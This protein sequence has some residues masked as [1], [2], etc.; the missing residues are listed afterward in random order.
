MPLTASS[1]AAAL[2]SAADEADRLAP[3]LNDLDGW[4]G[5]DC[6]TGANA[7]QTFA[8]MSA[9]LRAL[10]PRATFLSGLEIAVDA[11]IHRG[12]GHVSSL[13]TGLLATWAASLDA[14][15][16]PTPV[17]LRRMLRS[18][19]DEGITRIDAS[20]AVSTMLA[21]ARDDLAGLGDTLP[22]EDD[23]ISRFSA[24]AQMGL[25]EATNDR[26]GRIDA[27]GAVL[28]LLLTCLD[29]SVR[30]DPAML[31]SLAQMLAD[32]AA[33][34]GGAPSP[35]APPPGRGFTVDI[36]V[37]G[38]PSDLVDVVG[39]LDSLG[40]RTSYV[41]RVDL[42]GMGEWRLHVDTSAPLAALPRAGRILRFQ[43]AD[44]RPDDQIGVD[45]L[46]D[47]GLTHRGV[48][49]L[50]R[51]PV[52]RVERARVIACTR[53]PGLVEDLARAGAI[54][55]LDPAADD[56]AGLWQAA[57]S[58]STGIALIAPCDEASA[59]LASSIAPMIPAADSEGGPRPGLILA[60]TA[61]DLS[62]LLVAQAC[63]PLF[64][65]QPGGRAVAGTMTTMLR[66][67]ARTALADSVV[68]PI[69]DA[70]DD[71]AMA[72][73]AARVRAKGS[74]RCRLLVARGADGP[75][76]AATARQML[77]LE[78]PAVVDIDTRDGGQPGPSLLQGLA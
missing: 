42:F 4:D 63:A 57:A 15:A 5:S 35:Q 68:S 48:R 31:E 60:D 11:G 56:A 46:A 27:G 28:A 66:D 17:S 64:V 51:R 36:I 34:T 55:F 8:A 23:I 37:Q 75:L 50:E 76:V 73:A 16:A 70:L 49:L 47:E 45:D 40:A 43:V 74:I 12:V 18:L 19:P 69:P 21:G 54:V 7:A 52:R 13:L 65:P 6:D 14:D 53:A 2:A 61:D 39:R 71:E 25:V 30:D 77:A 78:A 1:L 38:M 22:D 10:D 41:G 24:Q 26:T 67:T 72:A 58:S 29:S 20:A 59:R 32:L 44:A 62:A 3:F 33:S 9:A